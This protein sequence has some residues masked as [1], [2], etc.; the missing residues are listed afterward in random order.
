MA[1][2]NALRL[3]SSTRW[4]VSLLAVIAMAI[5]SLAPYAMSHGAATS[6]SNPP[7]GV[8]TGP[9]NI[10]QPGY[11]VLAGNITCTGPAGY[12]I[13]I[14][15][16]G[17]VLNGEGHW[18]LGCYNGTGVLIDASNVTVEDVNVK[19]YLAGV[20]VIGSVLGYL[21]GITSSARL[22]NDVV[23]NVSVGLSGYGIFLAGS[24]VK[25]EDSFIW[26]S[27]VVGVLIF[28][29]NDGVYDTLVQGSGAEGVMV[30]G[31]HTEVSGV[32]A[33]NDTRRGVDLLGDYVR[34]Y[35]VTALKNLHGVY[36][37]GNDSVIDD[38]NASNDV[39]GI[40]VSSSYQFM[41]STATL[42][43]TNDTIRGATLSNDYMG[44]YAHGDNI[45]VFDS[46]AFSDYVGVYVNANATTIVNDTFVGDGLYLNPDLEN[47][48]Y[49]IANDTVN[50]RPLVFIEGTTGDTVSRAGE[51]IAYNSSNVTVIGLNLSRASIG[52][53]LIDVNYS[54]IIDCN[55]SDEMI[56][57]LMYGSYNSISN[58]T[59]DGDS[60][61]VVLNGNDDV[62]S[63]VTA[64]WDRYGIYV[65][66]ND[67]SIGRVVALYDTTSIYF[68]G[69][70]ST[71]SNL[72]SYFDV[73]EG[74]H[75][76]ISDVLINPPASNPP[77]MYGLL[78]VG[79]YTIIKDFRAF[80]V[81]YPLDVRG[82]NIVIMNSL[83]NNS[84]VIE[85][86]G[87][88]RVEG[89]NVTIY[90][91]TT[92]NVGPLVVWGAD[93]NITRLSAIRDWTGI[94]VHANNV[95]IADSVVTYNVGEG[96]D[97][98]GNW[99]TIYNTFIVFNEYGIR[100]VNS[101]GDLIYNNFLYN[102]FDA[103]VS[104]SYARWDVTPRPGRNIAGG[105][106]IAGNVWLTD[107]IGPSNFSA[108]TPPSPQ[109]PYICDQPFVINANNTDYYPLKYPPP[110][111]VTLYEVTFVETGLAPGT[112]WEVSLNG[113]VESST[114]STISFLVIKGLYTY[115][116]SA[117]NGYRASPSS[118]VINVSS[119][120]SVSI[121]FTEIN[122]TVTFLESG[123]PPG[124]TW[125]VTLNGVTISSSSHVIRFF[126][127]PGTY[128]Y[129][130][131]E[132]AGYE[133]SPSSGTIEVTGNTSVMISFTR[134][135]TT[136]STQ[137]T[138]TT[139]NTSMAASTT[140]PASSTATSTTTTSTITSATASYNLTQSSTT[141]K[142]VSST[143]TTS[144]TPAS[145]TTSSTG[146]ASTT[147]RSSG[148]PTETVLYGVVATVVVI[149]VA[150][151]AI[152]FTRR[153]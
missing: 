53:E 37:L 104:N 129:T 82:H 137:P 111:N 151:A 88:L 27:G 49:V 97:I 119:N 32:I 85:Y 69:S 28:G 54:N 38:V 103:S 113:S 123:L 60:K 40:Y 15:A 36:L 65:I 17:V 33:L 64:S 86:T 72:E 1:N 131:G 57:A 144:S 47:A 83:A 74:D 5:V 7:E 95:T 31:N 135:T 124:A 34:V 55:L 145:L 149:A 142:A 43:S 94:D 81:Y 76:F 120:A 91:L 62:I 90:N 30:F 51:V 118:G 3:N 45:R 9:A 106:M 153:S 29:D 100:L 141:P 39:Y 87:E 80:N 59:A 134:I 12:A 4:S 41:E 70:N 23:F 25:V 92:L 117:V 152:A 125:S 139:T 35:N 46:T 105:Y 2:I 13:G 42:T 26:G 48:S 101:Y 107:L 98:E 73:I 116:V 89:Y 63:G 79:N 93:F 121:K 136:T 78:V 14:F 138:T 109:D 66:G 122:Y 128:S 8:I 130:V 20:G 96:I 56:G 150:L 114:N 108:A 146:I 50:G 22:S 75:N 11:Y 127:P 148:R 68:Y 44:V 18:L 84:P 21:Y 102:D 132:V 140:A 115:L 147:L 110:T 77:H 112:R 52:A 24:N 19:G 71:L 58:V 143:T 126:V 61:G 16:S 6:S 67:T 133:A 99:T 10:T